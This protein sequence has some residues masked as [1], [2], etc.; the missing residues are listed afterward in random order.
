MADTITNMPHVDSSDNQWINWH[1]AMRARYG[2]EAAN[3]RFIQLW[4]DRGSSEAN[5]RALRQYAESQDLSISGNFFEGIGDNISK[6]WNG[7][8]SGF[9]SIGSFALIGAFIVLA[10]IGFVI[11]KAMKE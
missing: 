4:Q 3:T 6:T 1:K 8:G 10:I 9:S 7:L 5:T 2:K 11:Y